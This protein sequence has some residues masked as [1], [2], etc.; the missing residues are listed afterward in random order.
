VTGKTYLQEE[1]QDHQQ[2]RLQMEILVIAGQQQ[3]CSI[4]KIKR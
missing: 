4:A 3:Y 2:H 1:Q